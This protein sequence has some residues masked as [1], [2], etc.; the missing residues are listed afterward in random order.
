MING[1]KGGT[2]VE[3]KQQCGETI[4]RSMVDGVK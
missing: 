4:I 3:G 1:I 2:E